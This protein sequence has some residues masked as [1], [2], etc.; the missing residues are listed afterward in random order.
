M[1]ILFI[2]NFYPPCHRGG[3]E[4]WCQEIALRFA[5]AGHQIRVLTSTFQA[6]QAEHDPAYVYR[7]L[8]LEMEIAS[9]SNGLKFFTER[10]QRVA[11][12]LDHVRRHVAELKPDAVL[13]WG[14]WNLPFDVPALAEKLAP[15]RVFYYLGDYWPTLPPQ[16]ENYW[17]ARPSRLLTAIPKTL[18][19]IPARWMLKREVRPTLKLAH[20]L[21][22]SRYLR[23]ELA[24]QG[25]AFRHSHVLYGAIDTQPYRDLSR[26]DEHMS[27]DRP[28]QILSIG[29]LIADKGVKTIVLAMD[30]LVNHFN[31]TS[32]R[33]K[34]VGSGDGAYVA[35]LMRLVAE[36]Q[37]DEYVVLTGGVPKEEIPSLY[38]A[39]DVFVFASVWPEPFGRVIV[40][41]MASGVAVV[42][43]AVGGAAEILRPDENALTFAPQ[44]AAELAEQL[45]RL[46][47]DPA[48]GR[49]IVTQARHDAVEKFD[50]DRMFAEIEQAVS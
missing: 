50:L 47:N 43:T 31:I 28:V 3:Y 39:A 21:F 23:D 38:Q 5:A 48:M 46:I 41:A 29:R 24:T 44:D 14:M 27:D 19:A 9:L 49:R 35:E 17:A 30:R 22:C 20:G 15:N 18:L 13:V 1:R 4:E 32:V 26:V 6:A 10:K 8:N 16:F 45:K 36:K 42:G 33:L 37:L 11:Q 12:S 7:Q 34:I 40:E 2:S 25:V